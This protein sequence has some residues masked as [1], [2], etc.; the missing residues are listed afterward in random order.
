MT[1]SWTHSTPIYVIYTMYCMS[2]KKLPATRTHHS[3]QSLQMKSKSKSYRK[4]QQWSRSI[5]GYD[6]NQKIQKSI[7]SFEIFLWLSAIE[8]D[9]ENF[10]C[11]QTNFSPCWFKGGN[12]LKHR[13]TATS[14][15]MEVCQPVFDHSL[16]Y[17]RAS[18]R[19]HFG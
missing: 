12:G 14:S 3:R 9:F 11:M 13:S 10:Q 17:Q 5:N 1:G 16:I 6:F 15:F 19:H 18:F 7:L 2:L 4:S 8:C